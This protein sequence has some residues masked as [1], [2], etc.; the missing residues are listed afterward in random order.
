MALE[1][2]AVK[3]NASED[4]R[5]H[6]LYSALCNGW[7][8]ML[9]FGL[10]CDFDGDDYAAAR[11]ALIAAGKT[12]E[13]LCFEDM[14]IQL[15]RNGKAITVSDIELGYEPEIVGYLSL[16]TLNANWDKVPPRILLAYINEEDDAWTAVDFMQVICMGEITR[17]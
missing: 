2:S 6:I 17:G 5:L 4:E 9:H 1:I 11:D 12:A 10:E 14:L 7:N 15:V 13:E 16:A 3:V 8:E